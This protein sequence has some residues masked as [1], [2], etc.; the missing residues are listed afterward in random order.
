MP[1]SRF[2]SS[3]MLRVLCVYVLRKGAA[4][5]PFSVFAPAPPHFSLPHVISNTPIFLRLTCLVVPRQPPT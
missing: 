1:C 5:C 4:V 3:T 2:M